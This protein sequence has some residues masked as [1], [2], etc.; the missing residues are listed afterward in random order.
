[1]ST[2]TRIDW[3]GWRAAYDEM[4]FQDQ[5]A[6]YDLVW[7]ELPGQ[8]RAS[9]RSLTAFLEHID[10]PPLVVGELGGWDGALAAEVMGGGRVRAWWNYEISAQAVAN[11]VCEAPMYS[12]VALGD[13]YWAS[14][15][16]VDLFVSSH[17]IEHLKFRDVL[18]SFDATECRWIY[19]QAPL[20]DGPTNWAGYH[21]SHILEVGWGEIM[22]ALAGRGF[23]LVDELTV[24]NVRCFERAAS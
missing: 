11:S 10:G 9:A 3:D 20:R 14:S 1:M 12:G 6:F 15:H 4:S 8:A 16:L 24:P 13:W 18:A 21:G 19:L 17:V 5:R 22:G 2:A 23:R 7:E